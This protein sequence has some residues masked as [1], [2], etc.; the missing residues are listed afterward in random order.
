MRT[1]TPHRKSADFGDWRMAASL[2][3]AGVIGAAGGWLVSHGSTN[4]PGTMKR[5][6]GA[7]G[8]AALGRISGGVGNEVG[9]FLGATSP[10]A[11]WTRDPASTPDCCH[12]RLRSGARI[13][14]FDDEGFSRGQLIVAIWGEC[15]WKCCIRAVP[16]STSIRTAL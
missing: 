3:G 14:D 7:S 4:H 5:K 6:S 11:S 16:D 1:Q 15:L 9:F 8:G 10:L 13:L 2:V 12:E